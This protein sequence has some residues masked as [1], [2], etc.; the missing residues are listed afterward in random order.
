MSYIEEMQEQNERCL[1]CRWCYSGELIC[2]NPASEFHNMD[3]S[4]EDTTECDDFHHNI[5]EENM[6][7]VDTDTEEIDFE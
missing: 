1:K 6:L 4:T 7:R 5:C 3:T 2:V